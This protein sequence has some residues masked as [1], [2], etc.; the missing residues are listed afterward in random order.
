VATTHLLVPQFYLLDNDMRGDSLQPS[1]KEKTA[2][3]EW[4]LVQ[5]Q[6]FLGILGSLVIPRQEIQGLLSTLQDAGVRFVYFSPRNMRRQKEIAS[7]M[8]I[9]VAWNCAISLRPLD[10]GEEDP[11]RMVSTYGDWDV[12]AKLVS[13]CCH[14]CR[15]R[16]PKRQAL[17]NS[18]VLGILIL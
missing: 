14:P 17:T 16:C 8:G 2:S 3:G 9:D 5:N 18:F 11:H 10:A 13:R 4:P 1:Q 6:M 15:C 7:Q 12:N